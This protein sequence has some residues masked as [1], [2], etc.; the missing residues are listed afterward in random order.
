[1]H[2]CNKH[3]SQ[4]ADRSTSLQP[5]DVGRGSGLTDGVIGQALKRPCRANMTS[6]AGRFWRAFAQA[7]MSRP[8]CSFPPLR[9]GQIYASEAA[10]R[11]RG[12]LTAGR[13]ERRAGG[14][15]DA[16]DPS[17]PAT[18]VT[19]LENLRVPGGR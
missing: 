3:P 5:W 1:M 8:G 10:Q 6:L 13:R 4:P 9:P 14:F 19:E 16:G 17:W 15:H 18:H 11:P 12:R 7:A 2:E